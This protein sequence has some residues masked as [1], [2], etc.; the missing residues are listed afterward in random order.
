LPL[1]TLID[2]IIR[3]LHQSTSSSIDLPILCV[4]VI[5]HCKIDFG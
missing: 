1:V 2:K 4:W 3:D 5:E